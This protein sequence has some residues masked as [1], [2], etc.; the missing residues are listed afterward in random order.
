MKKVLFALAFCLVSVN[1]LAFT[2][3]VDLTDR[4]MGYEYVEIRTSESIFRVY[5]CGKINKG[6]I[7]WKEIHENEDTAWGNDIIVDTIGSSIYYVQ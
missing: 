4:N 1:V 5:P 2:S 7:S 6:V 3:K